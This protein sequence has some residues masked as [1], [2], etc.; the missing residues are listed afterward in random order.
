M[1][2]AARELAPTQ[3]TA[4]NKLRGALDGLDENDLNTRMQRS[5]DG[6]RSGTFSDPAE[7]ALTSDLQKLGQQI[8]DAA[9]AM[10]NAQHSSKDEA[11]NRAMDDLSRLRDQI[12]G[13]G[14][15]DFQTG[16]LS[17]NG[18]SGNGQFGQVGQPG[19]QQSGQAGGSQG[20]ASRSQSSG[21]GNRVAGPVGNTPGGGRSILGRI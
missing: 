10:G 17:R 7:T 4:S 13:I 15:K 20:Q 2:N 6:L 11:L 3:P 21:I 18:Q 14:G 19:Q 8:G 5:S 16:Q 12:G 1:R 9:R